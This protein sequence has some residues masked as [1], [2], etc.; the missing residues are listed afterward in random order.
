MTNDYGVEIQCEPQLCTIPLE[1][2]ESLKKRIAE[3]EKENV[4]LKNLYE[5]YHKAFLDEIDENREKELP[6]DFISVRRFPCDLCFKTSE[7]VK[8]YTVWK[9]NHTDKFFLCS[10][11]YQSYKKAYFKSK[12]EA[13]QE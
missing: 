3:L 13:K 8:Q 7:D 9:K 2:Y 12:N 1:E 10:D 4:K 11:C 6:M 5:H